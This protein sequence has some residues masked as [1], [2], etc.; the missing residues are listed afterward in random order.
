M[1]VIVSLE[2]MF[3]SF[4]SSDITSSHDKLISYKYVLQLLVYLQSKKQFI[5]THKLTYPPIFLKCVS[6]KTIVDV[7][8][9]LFLKNDKLY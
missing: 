9:F 1:L 3:Q 6:L 2:N 8:M 5:V 7:K 4:Y